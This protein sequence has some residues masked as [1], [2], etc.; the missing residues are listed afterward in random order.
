MSGRQSTSNTN[1]LTLHRG[2]MDPSTLPPPYVE[3]EAHPSRANDS[4]NRIARKP[5][6]NER[7]KTAPSPKHNAPPIYFEEFERLRIARQQPPPPSSTPPNIYTDTHITI[8]HSQ[9]YVGSPRVG[10]GLRTASS[11]SCLRASSTTSSAGSASPVSTEASKTTASSYVQTAYREARHFAGGL[12][13]HPTESTKHFT[14]LRHSHGLV[15][16]QGANT[17]L[18]ISVFADQPLPSNRTIWMQNRGW[19]GKT[20]MRARAFMGRN[21]NWINVTPSLSV[22]AEH[23]KAN[24]ERAWQ[25][26]IA[27]F[28]KKLKSKQQCHILRETAIIRIPEEAEDGYFQF[29]VCIG[30]REKVLCPS[31]VFRIISASTNP[32]SIRGASLKTL[33][34]ELGVMAF[35]TY[36]QN[37]AGRVV[38]P[39]ATVVQSRVGKFVPAWIAKQATSAVFGIGKPSDAPVTVTS[40]HNVAVTGTAI[41]G[42]P[43]EHGP[44]VPYPLRFVANT[45]PARVGVEQFN[46]PAMLLTG[47]PTMAVQQLFG[48]YFGWVRFIRQAM[49]APSRSDNDTW[50]SAILLAS[51]TSQG[52]NVTVRLTRDYD[53]WS[54]ERK[55]ADIRVM[56]FIRP[57]DPQQREAIQQ[58]LQ[59]GHDE[60][61]DAAMFAEVRDIEYAESFLDNPAWKPHSVS[62]DRGWTKT[63]N[64]QDRQSPSDTIRKTAQEQMSKVPLHKLG[65]RTQVV[66]I[67]QDVVA[68]NGYYVLR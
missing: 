60:A 39:V 65:I 2:T 64:G 59:A 11:S 34:I 56:G 8:E 27:Q 45:Q 29:V 14:I 1:N 46:V 42:V 32:S 58:G 43:S 13:T 67:R 5:V 18:A 25:R 12:I 38:G 52:K 30:D 26:D 15:F 19:S 23:L 24:D 17:T 49:K 20:G 9:N 10:Q 41:E 31:P 63:S 53:E 68:G 47:V 50:Y 35:K 37:T 3:I 57:D 36:A 61:A 4:Q 55:I 7:P 21:G 51:A 22:D 54:A 40:D 16:Y 44:Q 66:E 62:H 48:Y 28:Q 33:P 6:Y